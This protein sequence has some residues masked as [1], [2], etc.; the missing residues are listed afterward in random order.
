MCLSANVVSETPRLSGV[1]RD[2]GLTYP[3]VFTPRRL[4]MVLLPFDCDVPDVSHGVPAQTRDGPTFYGTHVLH[5]TSS[6]L[7]GIPSHTTD[8]LE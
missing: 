4:E 6:H 1:H 7:H 8:T 2:S 3:H 5:G